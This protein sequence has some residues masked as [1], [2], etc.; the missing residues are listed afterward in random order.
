L[1]VANEESLALNEELQSS[2]EELESSKEELQALNEELATVNA[3]LEDKVAEVARSHDDLNNLRASTDIATLLLDKTLHIRRF[4]PPAAKL[5]RLKSG[6]E[7]RLITDISSRLDDP[8][9]FAELSGVLTS[10]KPALAEVRTSA[11][12]WFLRRILPY[13]SG[14][15]DLQGV[16]VTFVDITAG[17][18]AAQ[19]TRQLASA[20]EDSNDAVLTYELDGRILSWNGAAQRVYGYARDEAMAIGLF[21]LTPASGHAAARQLIGLV[22]AADRAGP[23]DAERLS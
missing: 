2:N 8:G 15:S 22:R 12:L 21:G 3:Q 16:V 20:L 23:L 14:E 1:R 6:D 9:F 13:R 7:G 4:T 17:R 19:Q 11:D 10:L 18:A 5:F